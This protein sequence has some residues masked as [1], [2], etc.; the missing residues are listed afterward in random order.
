MCPTAAASRWATTSTTPS[1]PLTGTGTFKLGG[2]AGG[3]VSFGLGNL[4][5]KKGHHFSFDTELGIEFVSKP[6][7]ALA[8]TGNVCT[9]AQWH[10]CKTPSRLGKRRVRVR[11][12]L[13]AEQVQSDVNF[14]KLLPHRLCRRRL[15]TLLNRLAA[16]PYGCRP[17][18]R[19]T[20]PLIFAR[21][22]SRD[23]GVVLCPVS[24]AFFPISRLCPSHTT[25]VR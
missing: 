19:D 11:R 15:E 7:V 20:V 24:G 10:S 21:I 17:S 22:S 2:N 8:F 12:R 25:L 16:Q 3:R 4:V 6:T 13:G 18:H 9:S 14:L 1:G 23:A 5:P